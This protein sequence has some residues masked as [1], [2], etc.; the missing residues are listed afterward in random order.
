MTT[1][2]EGDI[3]SA[4][5]NVKRKILIKNLKKKIYDRKFLRLIKEGLEQDI[6]FNNQKISGMIGVPQG[7]IA[8]P[9][10]FNIYMH[11]FDR[12]V[13]EKVGKMLEKINKEEKRIK[14]PTTKE[15]KKLKS[16]IESN[17]ARI[18][19]LIEKHQGITPDNLNKY[20]ELVKEKRQAKKKI[21]HVQYI[22]RKRKLLTFSYTRYADDWIILTNANEEVCEKIKKLLANILRT[23]LK[24]ELS[25][26]KTKVTNLKK[27]FACFLGFTLKNTPSKVQIRER[28]D[29]KK[30][31]ARTT[32]GPKI[33]IDHEKVMKKLEENQIINK[34]QKGKKIKIRHVGKYCSLKDWEI[35]TKFIQIIRGIFNYYYYSLTGKGDLHKYYYLH[36][37][38]CLKT[39]AHR[40][41]I[42]TSKITKKYGNELK[43]KYLVY[44]KNRNGKKIEEERSVRFPTYKKLMNEI[45]FRIEA[46]KR[47]QYYKL[48]KMKEG[49]NKKL[50]LK[51]IEFSDVFKKSYVLEDPFKEENIRVNLRTGLK[52][53]GYCIVCGVDHTKKNPIVMH[54][55]KHIKKG[56]IKGFMEIM[57]SL[58]RKMIPVCEEC[59]RKIH[60]GEYDQMSLNELQD[61]YQAH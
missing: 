16:K 59:H 33:G 37:Y 45:G 6:I 17:R 22:D 21:L 46:E 41:R 19:R 1:A 60:R 3:N 35:V 12:L 20:K 39:L 7:G 9:I 8:S 58:N 36:K 34:H 14:T 56:Q 10:L 24:L 27:E 61:D 29:G 13:E 26:E 38:S 47:E 31:K 28:K 57:N 53:Y 55:V 52:I 51:E 54:H 5:D 11:K 48:E 32:L 40:L 2:I 43:I 25:N 42:S 44:L 15:Y 30:Y 49:I 23:E 50:L 4:F 18:K